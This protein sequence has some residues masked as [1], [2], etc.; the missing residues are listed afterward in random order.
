MSNPDLAR[1]QRARDIFDAIVDLPTAER[2]A[3][4][5]EACAGDVE[6]RREVESLL[7]HDTPANDAIGD[8]VGD[9][10]RSLG[11]AAPLSPGQ[12]LL[13]YD[14]TWQIGHG[15]MGDVW[16]ATDRTLGREVAIKVL[17]FA[18]TADPVRLGRFER[19][20]K[21]LAALNHPNIAAVYSLHRDAPVPFLAME[22]IEGEDL[23][24]RLARG[25]LPLTQ[26]LPIARQITEALEEAHEKGIVHRDLKPANIKL[27]PDGKVKVLDFGLAKALAGDSASNFTDTLDRSDRAVED[28]RVGVILGTAAY[29]PPEQ[30]RGRP[31]DKR[32][33]IWAFGAILF[34]MVSGRR[35]FDGGTVT[36]VL[37]AV[38]TT[39]PDWS[40]V[41]ATTPQPLVRLIRRC[42]EKDTRQRLRDIGDAR[43]D[44]EQLIAAQTD[45]SAGIPTPQPSASPLRSRRREAA[46]FVLG[47]VVSALA[48]WLLWRPAPDAPGVQRFNIALAPGTRLEDVVEAGRQSLVISN[49]GATVA[50]VARG[51]GARRQIYRRRIDSVTAEPVRGSEGGDMPFFSP[52]GR[53]LGF[54][55]DGQLKRVPIDGGQ[56]IVICDAP[57]PRGADWAD[58]DTIVFAAGVQT[59]LSRV[60][61]AG[62]DVVSVTTLDA[63]KDEEGHR[64]PLVL[65]GARAVVFNVETTSDRMNRRIEV[66]NF[67]TGERHTLVTNATDARYIDGYLLFGRAGALHAAPFNLEQLSLTGPAEPVL[68]DVRTNERLTGKVFA[69]TT[70]SGALVFVPGSPLPGRRSLLWIDRQGTT[71]P[72]TD[73][74]RAYT[75]ARISPDGESL[76]VV[77]QEPSG[78]GLWIFDLRR[79]TWNRLTFAGSV[80]TPAWTPDS[81]W[82]VYTSNL[83]GPQ[84]LF[85]VR[86]DGSGAPEELTPPASRVLVDMPSVAPSGRMALVAV[87]DERGDDIYTLLLDERR[88]LEPFLSTPASEA[89]PAISPSGR[90]YAHTSTESGR[91]EV[92]ARPFPGPGRKWTVS[93]AGG[94][95]PRWRAD[96]REIFY[97]EGARMMAAPV[98]PG[99]E[100]RIG[101]PRPIFEE[102]ALTWSGLDLFRY[103]VTADGQRFVIVRPED[104]EVAPLQIVLAPR[105][106]DE[107]RARLAAAR[108]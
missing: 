80:G 12:T 6:L 50:F 103:D 56:P 8:V 35:P 55:A 52:D 99:D 33:D 87:Q 77:I 25:P 86:A 104:R 14:L 72:V 34:E 4:L 90:F 84:R 78:R 23:S 10:A 28:T 9:A 32:A 89:S 62:G 98:E 27:K 97:V 47:V 21:L 67:E 36:D 57:E 3:K 96:E 7:A 102:P 107:L 92:Y 39:D 17:P 26:V 16:K 101:A 61:A 37:A 40:L 29:M 69:G 64:W 85:W 43:F 38:V 81:Q 48:M 44:L 18:V 46:L 60:P 53:W 74:L 20:A 68:D 13:H 75:V 5:A 31:V 45:S 71:T 54:A 106:G 30:A 65:P 108:R 70:R 59:G 58:D 42:L 76:A 100:L 51:P 73:E 88:Q 94:T 49:D 83:N 22:F 82:V 24:Q 95:S 93:T 11:A 66:L 91:R 15:G 79:G 2:Q 63:A 1:W 19:E 41:P 105:F